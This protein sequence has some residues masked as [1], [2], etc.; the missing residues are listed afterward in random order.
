MFKR[1]F[2]KVQSGG[3][4]ALS[5]FVVVDQKSSLSSYTN[6]YGG[7]GYGGR[8]YGGWGNGFATTNYTESDYL[9][10]TLVVDMLDQKSK[11]LLWQGVAKGT[12]SEKPEKREKRIPKAVAKLMK[13]FPVEPTK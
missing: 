10:G 12:I 2:K 5:L 13:K 6:Y 8:M 4:I 11:E 9:N 1:N 7:A 3:D